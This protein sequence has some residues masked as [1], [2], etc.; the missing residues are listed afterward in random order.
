V[1]KE[2]FHVIAE[3]PQEKHIAGDVHKAR[4]EKHAC[5]QGK[6]CRFQMDMPREPARDPCG[7]GG[8]GGNKSLEDVRRK[9]Q[10]VHKDGDVGKN[11]QCIYNWEI[12]PRI[13]VFEWYE[14]ALRPG[15]PMMLMAQ[16]AQQ[17]N[18]KAKKGKAAQK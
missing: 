7:Y 10:L 16:T 14:H 13:Q 6:K 12:A 2:I 11:Q 3:D 5:Q 8:V 18:G 4:M 1:P 15:A 17:S 9:R